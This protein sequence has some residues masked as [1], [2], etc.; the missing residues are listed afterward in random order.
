[1][2]LCADTVGPHLKVIAGGQIERVA[3]GAVAG[4]LQIRG[5]TQQRLQVDA[6]LAIHLCD[7]AQ[8]ISHINTHGLVWTGVTSQLV[9]EHQWTRSAGREEQ[10]L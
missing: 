9:D 5:R 3:R 8:H 1:M 2:P 7:C 10:C 4:H 6:V